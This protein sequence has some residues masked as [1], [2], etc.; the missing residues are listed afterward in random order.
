V[1]IIRH[2]AGFLRHNWGASS[3]PRSAIHAVLGWQ[4]VFVVRQKKSILGKEKSN[5]SKG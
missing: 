4:D 2:E 5:K 1:G 3:S